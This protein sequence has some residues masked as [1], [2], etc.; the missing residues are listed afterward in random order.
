MKNFDHVNQRTFDLSKL[1]HVYINP[2]EKKVQITIT[3]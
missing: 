1:F 2:G 3:I